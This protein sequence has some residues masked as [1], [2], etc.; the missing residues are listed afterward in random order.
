MQQD[1][2]IVIVGVCASGKTTLAKGLRELGYQV[3]TFAQEH[4]VSRRLWQRLDP[5][6]LI[7]L[8]CSYETIRR[9]KRI[10]WGRDRYRR[11]LALLSN[12]RAYADLVVRTDGFSP[13]QLVDYV[14]RRLR[15]LGIGGSEH[16]G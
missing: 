7:V 14:H 15:E 12:A 9:R 13:G 1:P 6:L 3:R 10:S 2:L 4:S 8:E 5:D 16:G 11:Q